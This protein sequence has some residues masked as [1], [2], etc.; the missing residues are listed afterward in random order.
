[1]D[2]ISKPRELSVEARKFGLIESLDGDWFK[3]PLA[4]MQE[5][6][7]ASQTF[8]GLRSLTNKETFASAMNIARRARLPVK[9]VRNHLTSLVAA[10]W[11]VNLGR[12]RTSRG[13]P[14]RTCTIRFTQRSTDAAKVYGVLPWWTCCHP[15][16]DKRINWSARAVLSVV[17][18]RLMK[19]KKVVSVQG[20]DALGS[21]QIWDRIAEMGG[22][23]QFLFSLASLERDTG[24]SRESIIAAK[25]ELSRRKIIN[26]YRGENDDGSRGRDSLMP[27]SE[28]QVVVTPVNQFRSYV[29]F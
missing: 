13:A 25:R 26:W 5:V 6:G 3:L 17:M 2:H 28:F 29:E 20:G 10:G 15:K 24:L 8:A 19:L 27:S 7:P 9:T 1:M 21:S 12:G 14:R 11:I 22:A 4:V 18:A 23:D 16:H